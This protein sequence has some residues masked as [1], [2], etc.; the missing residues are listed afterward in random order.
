MSLAIQKYIIQLQIPVDD[1]PFMQE[2]QGNGHLNS[3]ETGKQME[4]KL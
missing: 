3:I 4:L 1:V 2:E